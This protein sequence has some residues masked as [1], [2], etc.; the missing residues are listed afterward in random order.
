MLR[1]IDEVIALR[2]CVLRQIRKL[3]N[4]GKKMYSL[5]ETWVNA[6]HT[7]GKVWVDT[8][9]KSPRQA[10]NNGLSTGL[11]DPS[12]KGKRLIILHIESEEGFIED[13]LLRFV[14]K[15]NWRLSRRNEFGGF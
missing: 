12:G 11:K 6:R 14:F 13:G 3:R 7:V 10:F 5:D 4:E 8:A 2:R 9:V 1:E 15:K